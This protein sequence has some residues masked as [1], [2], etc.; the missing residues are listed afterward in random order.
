VIESF[1]SSWSWRLNAVSAYSLVERRIGRV[2]VILWDEDLTLRPL[3]WL[4]P[5][6]GWWWTLALEC[7]SRPRGEGGGRQAAA[8]EAA[9]D[10]A[11]PGGGG[12]G[13][14]RGGGGCPGR[15]PNLRRQSDLPLN[16]VIVD[17]PVT[18][19]ALLPGGWREACPSAIP[20]P[21]SS[22]LPATVST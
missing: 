10:A 15:R 2:V 19:R 14:A 9:R 13:R 5:R 16:V 6:H 22:L 11:P 17:V 8:G 12:G 7:S 3:P 21:S 18:R 1:S 4:P 20:T